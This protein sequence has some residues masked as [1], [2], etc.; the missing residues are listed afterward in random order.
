MK[1]NLAYLL[2]SALLLFSL[3]ACGCTATP[4]EE[5]SGGSGTQE[6]NA[7]TGDTQNDN[8]Q[9]GSQNSGMNDS[10][11]PGQ[12][13]GM[14]GDGATLGDTN[15]DGITDDRAPETAEDT[16]DKTDSGFSWGGILLAILAAAAVVKQR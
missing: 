5:S 10:M 3:T 2:V 8:S 4:Q 11:N 16:G 9:N 7:Q 13:S 15:G 14:A 1:R 6:E 12:N